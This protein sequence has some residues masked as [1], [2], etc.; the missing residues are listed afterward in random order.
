VKRANRGAALL[1]VLWLL[2]LMAGLVAVFAFSARVEA[3]QGSALRTQAMGRLAAEA[4]IEVAALRLNQPDPA[5]RWLPDGRP[6]GFEFEGQRIE[7][8]IVDESAKVDLNLADVALLANLMRALG[9]EDTRAGQLAAVIQDWRDPDDL[10]SMD[11]GAEDRDYAAA[12]REYG[13]RD[14]PFTTVSELQQLLGMDEATYRLLAPHVTIHGGQPRPRPDFAQGAVLQALGLS[15]EQVAQLLAAREAWQ[16]GL[17]LPVL[18][19]GDTLAVVGSGTYSV[20]SR[21][22]RPD[23]RQVEVTATLRMGAAAGLGQLYAP[24]AWRV[25]EPD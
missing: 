3:I 11:G 8:R 10:L 17:P 18:P 21:A 22:V 2:L 14:A 12:R 4:G 6:Y 16:P 19:G 25:G 13:A 20:A 23:G 24:L 15:P 1:L 9:V 7:L 5:N